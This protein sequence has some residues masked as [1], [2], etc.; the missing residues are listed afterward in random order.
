MSRKNTY[1]RRAGCY[2]A[3][4]FGAMV[5]VACDEL[6]LGLVDEGEPVQLHI[7]LTD[8][9]SDTTLTGYPTADYIEIRLTEASLGNSN[10]GSYSFVL[11]DSTVVLS[12]VNGSYYLAEKFI[13]EGVF[14]DLR[15]LVGDRTVAH[16]PSF[17]ISGYYQGE[18]Y[19]IRA[20]TLLELAVDM[21]PPVSLGRNSDTLTVVTL[22]LDRSKWFLDRDNRTIIDPLD[23]IN[24]ERILA[25]IFASIRPDK[26][27][28]LDDKTNR[29][30]GNG[31]GN[32]NQGGGNDCNTDNCEEGSG[33]I[34][35]LLRV[36]DV[37][38]SEGDTP[39]RFLV[40]LSAAADVEVS[41]DFETR[42]VN[43]KAGQDFTATAGTVVL[44]PGETETTVEVTILDDDVP[45]KNEKFSVL[46][47]NAMNTEIDNMKMK[48]TGTIIDDD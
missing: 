47:S 43:A 34:R 41:V 16:S 3:F 11:Q 40:T 30:N 17:E 32:G 39:F 2:F 10:T 35:H 8:A 33:A 13:P 9:G 45:E 24:S 22:V 23:T 29:S 5:V 4:L 38:G 42:N 14:G 28:T 12:G 6:M 44:P 15:V 21:N 27:R 36:G 46:L 25:N 48:G 20:D 1:R 31:N 26:S 7:T 37:S 18:S 19:T